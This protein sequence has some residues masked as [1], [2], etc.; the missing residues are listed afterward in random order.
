MPKT[1]RR[2]FTEIDESAL[3]ALRNAWK[4]YKKAHPGATQE[5]VAAQLNM[6]QSA[7]S[8]YLRG[9][10][11]IGHA[12]ALSFASFFKVSPQQIRRD[13]EINYAP[14]PEP[15]RL[16]AKQDAPLTEDQRNVA[17]AWAMLPAERQ[18]WYLEIIFMEA[19]VTRHYPWLRP[20]RRDKRSYAGFEDRIVSDYKKKVPAK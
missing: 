13:I 4:N 9:K 10:V 7:F 16:A 11:P 6:T 5:Q 2:E 20:T 19:A 17:K 3:T 15:P 12:V 8:Q 1:V 14:A 18:Q